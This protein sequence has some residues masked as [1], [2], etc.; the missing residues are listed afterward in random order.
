MIGIGT[1]VNVIAVVAGGLAGLLLRK[2]LSKRITDTV[3]Q[4]VGLAVVIVGLTGVF[5]VVNASG[6]AAT[7][8][9]LIMIISLAV[10]AAIGE[11]IN[12]E[13]KLHALGNYCEKR[14]AKPGEKST[15][16]RGFIM[17]TLIF[18]VGSMA[19]VG[20]FEEGINRNSEILFAKSVIDGISAIV[21]AS[22]M[23]YG[24]I[25][26]A[27][28]VGLYQGLLTLLAVFIAP[29][30]SDALIAQMSLI[31]SVLIMS[32]GFNI[33]EITKIRV[34]N[35]LPAMVIPIIYSFF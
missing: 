34:S 12:I 33:L 14:F 21:F 6:S 35:L 15:F 17:A 31:G 1:I 27:I 5:G 3:M 25:L 11:I 24:V 13:D 29:Y 20:A 8:Q 22:A 32:I 30:F 7:E 10:G 23:G 19:I 26:S 9:I 2:I 18:C 28:M 4:G 16:A